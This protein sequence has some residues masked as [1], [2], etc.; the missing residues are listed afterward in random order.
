MAYTVDM[1]YMFK[2]VFSSPNFRLSKWECSTLSPPISMGVQN[3]AKH[4]R[5][6]VFGTPKEENGESRVSAASSL[7]CTFGS[8]P[9]PNLEVSNP[10]T[11]V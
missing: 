10:L 11:L 2:G 8:F 4:T 1:S 3:T 5:L 7:F 6:V 9:S